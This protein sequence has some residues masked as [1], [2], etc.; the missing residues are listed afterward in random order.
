MTRA[1]NAGEL[2]KLRSDGQWA[3]W[4]AIIDKPDVIYTCRA[5]ST[6]LYSDYSIPFDGPSGTQTNVLLDMTVLVG[7]TAGG[8]EHGIGR[9]RQA[10]DGSDTA[11]VVGAD[12]SLIVANDDYITVLNDFAPFAKHPAGENL[13]F[14]LE[15]LDQFTDFVPVPVFTERVAV[16]NAGNWVDF[17]ASASWVPGSTISG[18]AWTF[19]GSLESTGDT[20]ATP[21]AHYA[22]A[23]R[24][25]V[26][27][28]VTAANGKTAIGYGWVYVLGDGMVPDTGIIIDDLEGEYQS[29]WACKIVAYDRP[30]IKDRARVVLYSED[31]FANEL[32]SIGPVTDRENLLMVGWIIGETIIREPGQDYVEFVVG[33]PGVF[34]GSIATM[35]AGLIDANYPEDDAATLPDWAKMCGLTIAKGIHYLINYRSTLA[36]V[37]DVYVEFTVPAHKMVSDSESLWGQ[38]TDYAGQGLLDITSD[39]YGHIY[40]QRDAA[41][42]PIASRSAFPVTMTFTDAD[43]S[44]EMA[45]IRRQ[46]GDAAMA[47]IEGLI[48][49]AASG[50]VVPVGGRAPG[51]Y[52]GPHGDIVN[53]SSCSLISPAGVLEATGL[54]YGKLNAEYESISGT[55]PANN[56]FVDVCPRQYV[57]FTVDG[58]TVNTFPRRLTL[59]REAESGGVSLEFDCEGEGGQYN[60]VSID[61][62]DESD[63]PIDIPDTPDIPPPPPPTDPPDEPPETSAADAVV[64]TADDVRITADLDEAS[65]TWTSIISGGPSAPIDSDLPETTNDTLFVIEAASIWKCTGVTGTPAWSEVWTGDDLGTGGGGVA[66]SFE[67]LTRIRVAPGSADLVYRT[68]L[69]AGRWR[70]EA[71]CFEIEQRR[72]NLVGELD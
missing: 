17:N 10:P 19:T 38:L 23:G 26:A 24:Y 12:P 6:L 18:Y 46:R 21:S 40:A 44:D 58:A 30:T 7:T 68:R 59:R 36:K 43:W 11:L 64:V 9:I 16:I 69:R 61:Y 8:S 54:L 70:Y 39:R 37:C 60:A 51:D 62:P 5:T 63:P 20:T 53:I 48:Y 1:P 33:G 31:Y 72:D 57:K 50:L 3:R 56:H 29:G 66:I 45:I 34:C 15:Y 41:L 2:T 55:H 67:A 65:P 13:D 28:T 47:E 14:D 27:L 4:R 25:R 49:N 71:V 42:Y 35:P 22:V 52:P 32:G